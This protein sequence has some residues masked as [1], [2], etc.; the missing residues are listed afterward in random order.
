MEMYDLYTK[1]NSENVAEIASAIAKE[2]NLSKKTIKNTYWSGLVHD[3]GK[4]LIPIKILNKKDKLTDK[5]FELIKEHPVLGSRALESSNSLKPIARYVKSHHERWDGRGYP[6]G[7]KENEIPLISQIL[8]VADAWDAMLSRR[9]YRDSM[10]FEYALKEIK[11]NKGTQFSPK[12]VDAFIKII[13]ND[14]IKEL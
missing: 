1:G 5:E 4:L 6:E 14:N 12:V 8:S 11:R 9:S 3:I 2:M 10:S 13:E 7:L